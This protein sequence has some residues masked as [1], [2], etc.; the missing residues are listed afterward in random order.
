MEFESRKQLV[1]KNN[2]Y[3][4]SLISFITVVIWI[5]FEIYWSYKQKNPI[6]N[7]QKQI[8]PLNPNIDTATIQSLKSRQKITIDDLRR[9]EQAYSQGELAP[10]P[11]P[12]LT[13]TLPTVPGSATNSSTLL[14]PDDF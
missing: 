10:P 8:E 9:L 5:G 12:E 4:L 3:K 14:T 11:T 1:L 7:I 13:T 2:L 6:P